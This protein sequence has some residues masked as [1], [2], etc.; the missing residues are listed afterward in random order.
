MEAIVTYHRARR[1]SGGKG[2]E[3]KEDDGRTH[4]GVVV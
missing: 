2:R 3:G 1:L 4:L